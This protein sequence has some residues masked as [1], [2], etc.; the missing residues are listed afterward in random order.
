MTLLL[1]CRKCAMTLTWL[2]RARNQT[3][4]TT[5]L[6]KDKAATQEAEA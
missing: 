6:K 2:E 1:R 5:C 3:L 4:C